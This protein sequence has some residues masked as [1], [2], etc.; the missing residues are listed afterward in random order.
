M[1]DVYNLVNEYLN[2]IIPPKLK[3]VS[4]ESKEQIITTIL[5]NN[6]G[7]NMLEYVQQLNIARYKRFKGLIT[8]KILINWK[9]YGTIIPLDSNYDV[10]II[11]YLYNS[12][13]G[14]YVRIYCNYLSNI[15][16]TAWQRAKKINNCNMLYNYN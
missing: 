13:F 4:M 12:D 8:A 5:K 6:L 14:K 1:T 7:N 11:N 9:P 10:F 2:A 3:G 15:K 16:L